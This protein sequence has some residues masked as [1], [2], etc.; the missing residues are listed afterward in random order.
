MKTLADAVGSWAGARLEAGTSTLRTYGTSAALDLTIVS[1]VASPMLGDE[2]DLRP[3]FTGDLQRWTSRATEAVLAYSELE[4]VRA[5]PDVELV[6]RSEWTAGMAADMGTLMDSVLGASAPSARRTGGPLTPISA[7]G[8]ATARA[9]ARAALSAQVGAMMGVLAPRIQGQYDDR[10]FAPG[11]PRLLLLPANMLAAART[12]QV[13]AESFSAWV[14]THE[15]THA[16]QFNAAPWLTD[17]LRSKLMQALGTAAPSSERDRAAGAG[18]LRLSGIAMREQLADIQAVM[19]LVEGHAE[20]VMDAAGARIIDG[21]DDL[22]EAM[23][24]RRRSAS[25]LQRLLTALLGMQAKARQY[26]QGKVFCD[27]V[28]AQAGV[29]SLNVAFSGPDT[30]PRPGEIEM[31]SRWMS[32]CL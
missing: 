22:R 26:Q 32:R 20:H 24:A 25:P 11:Q 30:L 27:T 12:L 10:L 21:V 3:Q 9:G 7:L 17:H 5:L 29:R 16:V 2:R 28:V 19:S 18:L 13:D 4:P 14:L 15:L 8:A 31:P 23:D 6:T 1:A